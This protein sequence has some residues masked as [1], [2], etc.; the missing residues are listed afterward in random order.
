MQT[1][2]S[3]SEQS[4]AKSPLR[5]RICKFIKAAL[6]SAWVKGQK[7]GRRSPRFD[8]GSVN[9]MAWSTRPETP[10]ES[11]LKL[12][13]RRAQ[14]EPQPAVIVNRTKFSRAGDA[15]A[16]SDH[17]NLHS[18]PRNCTAL[19]CLQRGKRREK[20]RER[21]KESPATPGHSGAMIFVQADIWHF[22]VSYV[23]RRFSRT[24]SFVVTAEF[25]AIFK[26]YSHIWLT[27]K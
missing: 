6:N 13:E 15:P 23:F 26:S 22:Y 19:L 11:V 24:F 7:K 4:R 3:L 2:G 27:L 10:A 25:T 17:H 21:E 16:P 1:F 18:A 5:P 9:N 8:Y 14:A 12:R 20:K